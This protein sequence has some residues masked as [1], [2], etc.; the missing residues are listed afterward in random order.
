MVKLFSSKQ[1]KPQRISNHEEDVMRVNSMLVVGFFAVMAVMGDVTASESFF[2]ARRVDVIG[3]LRG[4]VVQ[5]D[6]TKAGGT[7]MRVDVIGRIGSEGPAYSYT[8]P[9]S[10]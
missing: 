3:N 1:E 8:K 5:S 6:S 4:T 10:H 9:M 7:S 2:D